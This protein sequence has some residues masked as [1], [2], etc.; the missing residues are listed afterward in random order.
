M[1]D[2]NIVEAV[3]DA[4]GSIWNSMVN[5]LPNVIGAIIVLIIGYIVGRL[6]GGLVQKILEKTSLDNKMIKNTIVE[7]IVKTTNMSFE[8][9]IGKI[10][11]I[12]FYI[13]F[14]LAA[15]DIL[16][17]QMLTNFVNQVLLYLP[18]LL[19]GIIILVVGLI[20]IEWITKFIRSTTTEYKVISATLVTTVIRIILI[21]FV[22]MMALDQWMIDT[23]IIYTVI[24]PLA[25]GIAAAIA[26]AFG[27]GFKDVVADW[28]KNK[29]EEWKKAHK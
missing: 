23:S 4:F 29:A 21:F 6:I 28:S 22:L 8:K 17:I 3:S 15:V 11:A 27:W 2:W 19:A 12:F 26:V 1:A 20:A 24:Q 16:G 5:V 13:I 10:V 7:K 9:L 18:N 14:I 25:W